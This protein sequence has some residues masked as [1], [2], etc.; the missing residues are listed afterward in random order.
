MATTMEDIEKVLDQNVRP[1]LRDHGGEIKSLSFEDGIYRLQFLGHCSNCPSA[2]LT[3]E[4][5]VA[6]ELKG[7][8]PDIKDVVLVQQVSEELL[9]QARAL[10]GRNHP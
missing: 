2:Y 1:H 6:E 4:E 8:L 10:M 9:A 7:A 5:V 3:T